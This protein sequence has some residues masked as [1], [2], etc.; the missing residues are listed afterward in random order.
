MLSENK[1]KAANP[2]G[3]PPY[4]YIKQFMIVF[5]RRPSSTGIMKIITAHIREICF[6]QLHRRHNK[7]NIGYL[8][9]FVKSFL[10]KM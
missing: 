6:G 7:K 10:A 2:K 9:H 1:K 8:L 5:R 4:K 3:L